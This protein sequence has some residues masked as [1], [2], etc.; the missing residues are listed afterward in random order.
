MLT[1]ASRNAQKYQTDLDGHVVA[2]TLRG[3]TKLTVGSDCRTNEL[4]CWSCTVT[5]IQHRQRAR[6]L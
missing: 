6:L 2:Q 3:A 4:D 5:S 1:A